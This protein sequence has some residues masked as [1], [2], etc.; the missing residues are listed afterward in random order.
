MYYFY[1]K[2]VLDGDPRIVLNIASKK[3]PLRLW[4]FSMTDGQNK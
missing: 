1:G 2:P 4:V 3:L